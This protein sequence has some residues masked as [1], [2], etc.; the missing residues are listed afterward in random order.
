MVTDNV[1]DVEV[2]T[3]RAE[4]VEQ[5]PDDIQVRVDPFKAV[6]VHYRHLSDGGSRRSAKCYICR[7]GPKEVLAEIAGAT[8][9]EGRSVREGSRVDEKGAGA[10]PRDSRADEGYGYM[11]P[12]ERKAE[13]VSSE[14]MY[15]P[16]I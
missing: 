10:S 5:S 8:P 7:A 13:R 6:L 9:L 15:G 11:S 3:V 14:D 12:E 2:S 4:T 16:S 1:Q